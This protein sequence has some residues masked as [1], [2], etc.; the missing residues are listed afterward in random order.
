MRRVLVVGATDQTSIRRNF[1]DEMTARLK[2]NALATFPSYHYLPEA[3]PFSE[4]RLKEAARKADADAM[5]VSRL[6]R[7]EERTEVSPGYYDPYPAFGLYGWRS[8][9]WY[10]GL[11]SPPRVY[12][13]PVYFTETTLYDIAKNE[14]IWTGT[15][16]TI[17]PDDMPKEIAD[18][19]GVV[20]SA[21][22]AENILAG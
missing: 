20:V 21:L 6:S 8:S 3:E 5:I 18:Y 13:Y 19:V 14:V 11:Y 15:I 2:S 12:R 9:L 7:V 1:E 4:S 17:N 10:R 22:K 16:R